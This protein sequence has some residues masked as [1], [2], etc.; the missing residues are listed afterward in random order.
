M[1]KETPVQAFLSS[2]DLPQAIG[3]MVQLISSRNRR[4]RGSRRHNFCCSLFNVNI[5]I[6]VSLMTIHSTMTLLC[7]I[8]PTSPVTLAW[9]DDGR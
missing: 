1:G 3:R 8:L 4:G 7:F 2:T 9:E 6:V 5:S